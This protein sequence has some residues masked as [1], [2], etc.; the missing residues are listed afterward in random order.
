MRDQ[1]EVQCLEFDHRFYRIVIRLIV[2]QIYRYFSSTNRANGFIYNYFVLF[3]PFQKSRR[4]MSHLNSKS[5][6]QHF[7]ALR[8]VLGCFRSLPREAIS[9][10]IPTPWWK[11]K[12][13]SQFIT[14]TFWFLEH[15][16][17]KVEIF[18]IFPEVTCFGW[19]GRFS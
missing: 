18:I 4:R 16:I 17:Q 9:Y 5:R 8:W 7:S 10:F 6:R 1:F 14:Q 12:P 3:F 15:P 13:P 11:I 19:S 2:M